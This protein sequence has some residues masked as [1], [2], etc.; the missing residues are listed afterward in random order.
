MSSVLTGPPGQQDPEWEILRTA[1]RHS[2][3]SLKSRR[4]L[5]GWQDVQDLLFGYLRSSVG[6]VTIS[7]F[8]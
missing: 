8:L 3:E 1:E 6:E 4:D 7:E 2:L 5:F